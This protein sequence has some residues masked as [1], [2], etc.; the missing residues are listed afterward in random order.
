MILKSCDLS[1]PGGGGAAVPASK[2][3]ALKYS[4]C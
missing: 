1:P 2:P 4:V 3:T